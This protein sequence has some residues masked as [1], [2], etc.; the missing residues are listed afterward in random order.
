[1]RL[2]LVRHG[3]TVWNSE[4]RVQ[5]GARDIALSDNGRQQ[6]G[7][8]AHVLRNEAI[9][10]IVASPLQRAVQ[11]AEAIAAYHDL[12]I[13]T[14]P[15]LKEVDVG[16]LDGMCTIGMPQT[17]TQLLLGWWKGD[18]DRL[19]GGES[20]GEL[21]ERT[22]AAVQPFVETPAHENV[23]IVSHYFTT[24]SIIFKALELPLNT[25]V[26]F[27]MDPACINYLEFGRFGPRLGRFNDTSYLD[28]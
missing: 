25:L 21:Q 2:I 6:I 20:F 14:D 24:L 7:R 19:P 22:W 3:E 5:G 12:P 16:E 13:T 8:L 9:D 15:R 18:T 23:L 17:F 4:S 27:R 10:H 1:M 26:K 28:V 11:T